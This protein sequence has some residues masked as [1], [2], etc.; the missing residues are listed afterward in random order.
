ML[1]AL[2]E[3]RDFRSYPLAKATVG[4]SLTVVYGPNGAGKSNLL[5]AICFG[6]TARSP[7]TRNEREL[8]HFGSRAARVSLQLR[9]DRDERHELMVG[10][11]ALDEG[12]RLEKR[13]RFDGAPVERIDEVEGRPLV[14]VFV[15]DRLELIGGGPALR[16]SHLD[17]LVT[18]LWP[19]RA[20]DRAEYSRAL[21]QRN[22]LIARIRSGSGSAASL[23]SWDRTLAAHAIEL[24]EGRRKAVAEIAAGFAE[25][26]GHLGLAGAATLEYRPASKALDAEQLCSELAERLHADVDRGYTTYGPHRDELAF[27]R[28]GRQLR[29]YGS[30]GERRIALLALLL[31]ERATIAQ[32]R[33]AA[34][35][36]LLD[37]VMS[38]LD[39]R[40]REMLVA[41]LTASGGQSVIA[42]TELAHVPS[43]QA[44]QTTLLEV[45]ASGELLEVSG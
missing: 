8:I 16:R 32:A 36:M 38:E 42:T 11:G 21:A 2:A 13:I 19:S 33:G 25:R 5:E 7:R 23:G 31:A 44:R 14:S 1:L 12:S 9:D 17:N 39:E 45:R 37:D 43:V 41:E 3:L 28:D 40:R 26:C 30:Q 29:A 15:P 18:A 10:F 24:S 27:L 4:E 22:A 6:C 34:P 35:L 20:K